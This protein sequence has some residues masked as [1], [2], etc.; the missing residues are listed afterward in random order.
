MSTPNPVP[1][2]KLSVGQQLLS[3]IEN[4]GLV[5]FGPPVLSFLQSVQT[6]QGDPFKE[7]VAWVALQGELV[8]AAPAALGGLESQL[9]GII[10]AKVQARLTQA[11]AGA[12]Y[13][14]P[15]K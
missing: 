1:A 6:A 8:K 3:L 14:A 7:S 15:V 5:T 2:P 11:Q 4:D 12:Q 10:A 9:A 13:G